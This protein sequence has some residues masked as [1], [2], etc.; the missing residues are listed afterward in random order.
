MFKRVLV[1]LDGSSLAEAVLP[2]T[3]HLAER[4]GATIILFHTIEREA[5]ATV[6]GQRHLRN[7]D[8]AQA[9]LKGVA[10][11]LP[12]KNISV[13]TNVHPVGANDVARSIIDHVTELNADLVV[14]CA[15]GRGGWR[16]VV[17]GNIAQQVIQGGTTPVLF[18]RQNPE[19]KPSSFTCRQIL[20]PLDGTPIHEPALPVAAEVARV[21]HAAMHLIT[22]V[23]TPS[24]LSAERAGTGLLLPTTMAAVLDLAQRGAVEYLQG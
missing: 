7:A 12:G 24:T 13:E 16:D 5:P 14:L 10:K 8:E 17:V 3:A 15:H 9:Y 4:F 1:P 11:S 22:V 20:I 6:H 18:V 19:S 21:C 2:A 23:P